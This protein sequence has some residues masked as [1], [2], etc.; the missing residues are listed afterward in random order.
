[1]AHKLG[2]TAKTV[3]SSCVNFCACFKHAAY[4][5]SFFSKFKA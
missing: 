1:M 2:Y 5:Y 4:Y 3:S